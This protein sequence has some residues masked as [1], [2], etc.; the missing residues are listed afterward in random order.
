[1]DLIEKEDRLSS[2]G[3]VF[4][5]FGDDFYDV[6]FF[7]QDAREVKKLSIK[8][9][10]D[11]TSETRFSRSWWSPE[12]DRGKPSRFDK[13]PNGFSNPDQMRL[14]DDIIDCFWSHEWGK[15]SDVFGK[16]GVHM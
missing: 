9:V 10:R 5:C 2:L 13:F 6:F 7:W 3:I 11:H 16:E 1:M 4:L 8:W 14:S 12:E 15:W